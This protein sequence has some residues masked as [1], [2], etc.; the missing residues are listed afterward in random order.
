[1]GGVGGGSGGL[2]G[3]GGGGGQG[4]ESLILS[5]A[6]LQQTSEFYIYDQLTLTLDPYF[7]SLLQPRVRHHPSC[8]LSRLLT[9]S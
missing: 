1:M 8:R 9:K 5:L 4:F 3:A 7:S 2:D 6:P